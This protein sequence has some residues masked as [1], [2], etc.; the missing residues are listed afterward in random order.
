MIAHTGGG[1]FARF[2]IDAKPE[3]TRLRPLD[4]GRPPQDKRG[5]IGNER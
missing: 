1:L 2:R 4:S 5:C 3:T